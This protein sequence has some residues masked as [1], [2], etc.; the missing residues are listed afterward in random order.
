MLYVGVGWV[1]GW[2][3]GGFLFWNMGASSS[4]FS[5]RSEETAAGWTLLERVGGWVG[6]WVGGG[7]A[8]GWNELLWALYGWVGRWEERRT[9]RRSSHQR[10]E[11][12]AQQH[13]GRRGRWRRVGGWVGGRK[14]RTWRRPSH[15]R[16]EEEDRRRP[17]RQGGWRR[18]RPISR[19]KHGQQPPVHEEGGWVG[20]W[21]GRRRRR[22][23][24]VEEKK[25]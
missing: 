2:V 4:F 14:E 17:G 21:V 22:I 16:E 8:G 25:R 1:G 15:Q 5:G 20:G 13:P 3:G 11:E 19:N 23:Q 12:G 9:W 7:R 24:W 18:W 6:G 10:E